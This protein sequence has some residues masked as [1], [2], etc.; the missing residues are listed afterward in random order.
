MVV[1][2]PWPRDDDVEVGPWSGQRRSTQPSIGRFQTVIYRQLEWTSALP[3]VADRQT[4]DKA[5]FGVVSGVVIIAGVPK[6]RMYV[7]CQRDW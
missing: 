5:I 4:R 2:A 1:L 7:T 3:M 6:R